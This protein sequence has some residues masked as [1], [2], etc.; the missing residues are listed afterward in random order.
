VGR[1]KEE[2]SRRRSVTFSR[3]AAKG[4][5]KLPKHVR[6]A[7]TELLRSVSSDEAQGY[8]PRGDLKGLRSLRLGRGHRIVYRQTETEIQVID[9]GPRGDIYK[10]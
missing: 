8:K 2:G 5:E 10:R 1:S 3:T 7:C 4:Y 6:S 9:V